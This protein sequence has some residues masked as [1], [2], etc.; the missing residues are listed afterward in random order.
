[1]SAS[2]DH[3]CRVTAS[4]WAGVYGTQIDSAR[5]FGRHWHATYGL[6]LLERGA[7]SSASGRGQVD[8][9]AGDLITTNPGEVHDGR[10]L[11]GSRRWRMLYLDPQLLH[12]MR[13]PCG[14]SSSSAG[15][16]ELVRPVIRDARLQASLL[17]LFAG[18][19]RWNDGDTH[20]DD[21][22]ACE[23][24]LVRVCAQLLAGHSTE[25]PALAV[26]ADLAQVRERLADDPLHA[27]S[28]D[29][30]AAPFG[31]TKYQ[32]LRRFQRAYGLPPHAWLIQQR[33]ERAR[34]LIRRGWSLT[35]A[36][37]DSGFADQSHMTRAFARQFGFTPGAWRMAAS[38]RR[39]RDDGT[40]P[41]Q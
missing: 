1:M 18:L 16:L 19:D 15:S 8:A 13:A 10:P 27:P 5:A 6:G 34:D 40:A 26:S 17:R 20:D 35:D 12:S 22:L 41:P 11:G 38:A 33:V 25:A 21:A 9:C 39:P 7:Q 28:L 36:A 30:L 2:T 32:L 4:P 37:A 31:L 3:R 23:E 29:E 24:A 14:S